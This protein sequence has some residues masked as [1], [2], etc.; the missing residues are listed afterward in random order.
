VVECEKVT[1][2]QATVP[3]HMS[4]ESI[5]PGMVAFP[6]AGRKVDR[7][8]M[9]VVAKVEQKKTGLS[10]ITFERDDLAPNIAPMPEPAKP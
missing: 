9:Y 5:R 4:I 2:A 7:S 8:T 3:A 1:R 6:G 10:M